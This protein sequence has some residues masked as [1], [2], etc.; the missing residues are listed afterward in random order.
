M[1][2][3]VLYADEEFLKNLAAIWEIEQEML[4]WAW[5]GENGLWNVIA[6]NDAPQ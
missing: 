6:A 3:H 5:V 4:F 1:N 2:F